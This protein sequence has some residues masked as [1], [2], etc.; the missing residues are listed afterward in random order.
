MI[1]AGALMAAGAGVASVPFSV[2]VTRPVPTVVV[3]TFRLID[4]VEVPVR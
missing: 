2:E 3:Q 4:A 1:P